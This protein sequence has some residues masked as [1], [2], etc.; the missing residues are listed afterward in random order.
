MDFFARP[1]ASMDFFAGPARG[2]AS[3]DFFAAGGEYVFFSQNRPAGSEYGFFSV[4]NNKSILA[5]IKIHTRLKPWAEVFVGLQE[6]KAYKITCLRA[7][8][9][10]LRWDPNL[11]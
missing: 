5:Q 10:A 2:V 11:T 1:G 9:V 3:M 7:W 8:N 4:S 6:T